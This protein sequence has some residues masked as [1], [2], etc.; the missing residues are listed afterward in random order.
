MDL[1]KDITS[2]DIDLLISDIDLLEAGYELNYVMDASDIITFSFPYGIY[3]NLNLTPDDI[4]DSFISYEYIFSKSIKPILL[5]EYKLELILNRNSIKS[6]VDKRLNRNLFDLTIE[7]SQNLNETIRKIE[8]STTFLLATALMQEKLVNKFDDLFM[9]KLQVDEIVLGNKN[10]KDENQ[11]NELFRKVK[12]TDWV[13]DVFRIWVNTKTEIDYNDAEVIKEYKSTLRDFIAI[14][15]L[16]NINKLTDESTELKGKYI[17]LYFSGAKKSADIFKLKDVTNHLPKINRINNYNILRT[18]KH[19]FLLFLIFDENLTKMKDALLEFKSIAQKK[20]KLNESL[21]TLHEKEIKDYFDKLN[22]QRRTL[23]EKTFI[24]VQINQ[25]KEF[26]DKIAEKIKSLKEKENLKEVSSFYED[27]LNNAK[28]ANSKT[29]LLQI[30]SSYLLQGSIIE[31]LQK[32]KNEEAFKI[33]KGKDQI[34]GDYHH[35][36]ILIFFDCNSITNNARLES[37]YIKIIEYVIATS[38]FKEKQLNEL[39]DSIKLIYSEIENE[40]SNK[41]YFYEILIKVFILLFIEKA[42]EIK[43]EV[44][45]IIED[46]LLNLETNK[47]A[48]GKWA[49]DYIYTLIWVYRRMEQ[50]EKS[51]YY[52]DKG[53]K[54]FHNDPRFYHGKSLV[55]YN[56]SFNQN[57]L[58]TCSENQLDEILHYSELSIKMYNDVMNNTSICRVEYIKYVKGSISAINNLILYSVSLF[59]LDKLETNQYIENQDIHT[60]YSLMHLR[61]YILKPIKYFE[62]EFQNPEKGRAE[63]IHTESIF[64]LVEAIYFKDI[65][66]MEYSTNAINEALKMNPSSD[67]Y[68][69]TSLKIASWTD[70]I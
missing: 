53:I 50:F 5:D 46:G 45:L 28:I 41:E 17:F 24:E 42:D 21:N 34:K 60:K 1:L 18:P 25:H 48:D 63:Y 14:D 7:T 35:L 40:G 9:N 36:P 29:E 52:C 33:N 26:Q 37:L 64:E 22:L 69:K 68:K 8:N 13:N 49:D 4:G 6:N 20:E 32:L 12:R 44:A 54:L 59:Y 38:V 61:E 16:C 10:K 19:T 47:T 31:L 66:K 65:K 51:E 23:I 43:I 56:K 39:I 27:L 11:L 3:F 2:R 57:T 67:L 70:K 30:N 15:R 55:L 62:K 58:A